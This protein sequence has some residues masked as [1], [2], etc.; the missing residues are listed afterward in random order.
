MGLF[1]R[2]RK[3]TSQTAGRSGYSE[4][5]QFWL[6]YAESLRLKDRGAL[7]SALAKREE[8][9]A[10]HSPGR[11]YK[12][13]ACHS[14]AILAM[15]HLGMGRLAAKY[16][17]DSLSFGD[18]YYRCS[19]EHLAE[20][21]FSAHLESLQTAAMTA[22]SYDE[23]L[24]YIRQGETLY[25]GV[26]EVKRKE[27]EAFRTK[28]PRYFDYQRQTSFLYYSRVSPDLDQGD[29]APAMSLLQLML[30]RAETPAYD[31]SY[32]EYVD[33]LD[34]YGTITAMYLMKK[35]RVLGGTK[36]VFARELAFIADEPLQHI[37]AFLPDC[38]P[39]DRP[40]IESIVAAIGNFPGVSERDAFKT[41]R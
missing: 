7:K 21:R 6:L 24:D 26:F 1:D 16:A 19:Q 10:N 39:A 25:G 23:A 14:L 9:C 40:K 20:L 32:E 11:G 28:H 35:A 4:E 22:A 41:F 36:E 29:Y 15:H 37:A 13:L 38:E 30:D 33:I 2:F 34:D 17:R 8:I 5:G 27:L 18:D 3:N 31:L 12:G